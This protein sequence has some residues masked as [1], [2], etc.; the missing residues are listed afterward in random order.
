MTGRRA[1]RVT[2]SQG[3]PIQSAARCLYS[4]ICAP[5]GCM[6][7]TSVP[8]MVPRIRTESWTDLNPAVTRGQPV[9]GHRAITDTHERDRWAG[10]V[11]LVRRR[12]QTSEADETKRIQEDQ[13]G[14]QLLPPTKQSDCRSHPYPQLNNRANARQTTAKQCHLP[15][16]YL[17]QPCPRATPQSPQSTKTTSMTSMVS[18]WLGCIY[19]LFAE[20]TSL[21]TP[22]LQTSS[23][24]STRLHLLPPSQRA[25]PRPQLPPLLLPP[26]HRHPPRPVRLQTPLLPLPLPLLRPLPRRQ[27]PRPPAGKT[28]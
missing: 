28:T 5:A 11:G 9:S 23:T 13:R 27:R 1:A 18:S 8:C 21:P 19:M 12:P 16:G 26:R 22:L 24:N 4:V 20:L 7:G 17:P 3:K 2:P 15:P 25:N 14:S 10:S 6:Q